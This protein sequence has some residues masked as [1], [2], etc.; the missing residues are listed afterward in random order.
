MRNFI[1]GIIAAAVIAAAGGYLYLRMGFLVVTADSEPSA[2]EKSLANMTMDASMDRQAPHLQNPVPVTDANLI[3]GMKIYTMSCAQCHGELNRKPSEFGASFF[4]RAPQLV[5]EPLD[6]PEWHTF[7]AV[8]HGVG[9]T[10]MPAWGKMMKDE[11][12]WKVTSFLSRVNK[13]PPAVQEQWK[14]SFGN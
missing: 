9:R 3:D 11:D 5:L 8:K 6:D 12:I 13:L 10:G 14:K 7:Y 4:P 1:L 2:M